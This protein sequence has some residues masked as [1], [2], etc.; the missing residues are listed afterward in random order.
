MT[1]HEL[2]IF[3]HFYYSPV[4]PEGRG[5]WRQVADMLIEKGALR[6]SIANDSGFVVTDKGQAWITTILDTPPP[7]RA[8]VD[9]QGKII[10]FNPL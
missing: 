2:E 3:L 4:A 7:T 5:D 1:P 6:T 10:D 8:Y 9:Q